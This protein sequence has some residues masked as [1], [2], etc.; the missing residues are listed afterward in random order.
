MEQ[1]NG[2]SCYVDLPRKRVR[3]EEEEEEEEDDE[4][5]GV[6]VGIMVSPSSLL[7]STLRNG[8]IMSSNKF[9][10]NGGKGSNKL[11]LAYDIETIKFK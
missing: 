5:G 2:S 10:Y 6:D 8:T 11:S 1:V 4:K 3:V 9:N 7:P